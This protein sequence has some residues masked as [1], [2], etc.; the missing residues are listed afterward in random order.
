[1]TTK[2]KI[3][4]YRGEC[5]YIFMGLLIG[6]LLKAQA[7]YV[8]IFTVLIFQSAVLTHTLSSGFKNQSASG[9]IVARQLTPENILSSASSHSECK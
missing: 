9:R 8:P 6:Y 7:S 4:G 1:M 2:K 5:Y 3:D